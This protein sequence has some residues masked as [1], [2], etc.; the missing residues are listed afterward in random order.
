M[1]RTIHSMPGWQFLVDSGHNQ[2]KDL[3]TYSQDMN[4]KM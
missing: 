3:V 2:V 1:V 4:N